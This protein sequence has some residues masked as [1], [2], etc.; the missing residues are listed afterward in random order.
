MKLIF[1]CVLQHASVL[2]ELHRCTVIDCENEKKRSDYLV[3]LSKSCR[4]SQASASC[5]NLVTAAARDIYQNKAALWLKGEIE[6]SNF[7]PFF[8]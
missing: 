8:A 7:R 6:K 3:C 5:C 1:S 4:L 2:L